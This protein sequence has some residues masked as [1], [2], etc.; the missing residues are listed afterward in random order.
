MAR[1]GRLDVEIMM[2]QAMFH[3]VRVIVSVRGMP[4]KI[5]PINWLPLFTAKDQH[6]I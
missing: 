3:F 2:S 4:V 1:T 6:V 5:W